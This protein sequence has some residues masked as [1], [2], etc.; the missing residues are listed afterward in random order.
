VA[1]RFCAALGHCALAAKP[2]LRTCA[3]KHH[4]YKY[5]LP[6]P[7]PRRPLHARRT[8]RCPPPPAHCNHHH[9]PRPDPLPTPSPLP[10]RPGMAAPRPVFVPPGAGGGDPPAAAAPAPG[11]ALA[12]DDRR[13]QRQLEQVR[14]VLQRGRSGSPAGAP[15][16]GATP[17]RRAPP[18]LRVDPPSGAWS[19]SFFFFFFFFFFNF[20]FFFFFL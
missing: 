17:P 2:Q 14:Q 5:C 20:F 6:P 18:A 16:A 8:R 12:L 3:S 11:A 4:F 13:V 10:R 9:Q 19:C 15:A 1:L 7:T